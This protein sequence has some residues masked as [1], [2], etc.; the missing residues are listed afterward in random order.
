MRK[1]RQEDIDRIV[2][3]QEARFN[4]L[5]IPEFVKL[6]LS[7]FRYEEEQ[8][9]AALILFTLAEIQDIKAELK[10]IRT[11][12]NFH[13]ELIADSLEKLDKSDN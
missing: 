5:D 2:S 8:S 4:E 7:S 1:Y 6:C 13:A 9:H 11:A 10:D 12:F 3:A